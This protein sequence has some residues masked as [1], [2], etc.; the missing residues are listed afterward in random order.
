M[1]LITVCNRRTLGLDLWEE[2]AKLQGFIPTILGLGDKRDLG[3]ESKRFGLKFVL[4]A[5]HLRTLD[6]SDLCLVTD[7]YD[8][9]FHNCISLHSILEQIPT[10]MLAFAGDV[11]ENPDQGGPYKTRHL[12][13]PYLNSGVYAGRA[14]TILDVLDA[15]LHQADPFDLD[16]Q[17]Y[18]TQYMFANPQ[19]IIVDH[20]CKVF[21]CMAGLEARDYSVKDGKL[22]VFGTSTPSVIHFQGYY[23]DTTIVKEL[24]PD[25]KRVQALAKHLHR[26]PGQCMRELGD[27]AKVLVNRVSSNLPV[28]KEYA[29]QTSIAIIL[30]CLL[31]VLAALRT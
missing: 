18:F 23:K 19:R 16:D 30:L 25:N 21:V 1:H 29:I 3:H 14:G 22:V 15:A 2:T 12:R 6:A 9:I 11:Y 20:E 8:V 7:G 24:Y 5:Q 31:L 4:L 17:R 10:H 26:F 28:P 13:I 27:T